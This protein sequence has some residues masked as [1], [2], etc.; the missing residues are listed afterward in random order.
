MEFEN[1]IPSNLSCWYD[2]TTQ[3]VQCANTGGASRPRVVTTPTVSPSVKVTTPQIQSGQTTLDKIL[4]TFL[5]FTAL[6]KNAPYVPTTTQPQSYGYGGLNN[7]QVLPQ[8]LP[9]A[10]ATFG[11]N[12]QQFVENNTGLLLIIGGAAVL[13]FMSP[14]R[15]R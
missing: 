11:A 14:P 5:Q 2:S 13:L 15:R 1:T 12:L 9:N 7:S 4:S 10:G 8:A 6:Q 3:S